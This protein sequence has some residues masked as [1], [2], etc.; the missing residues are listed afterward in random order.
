MDIRGLILVNEGADNDAGE[1]PW[2]T[3]AALLEVAGKSAV[4]RMT[5]RLERYG[6]S[7]VTTI[8]EAQP[9]AKASEENNVVSDRQRFWRAAEN[10]FN[11]MAQDGA[12][13]V[14]VVRLGSYAEADF[15]RLVQYHVE[16][17]CRVSKLGDAEQELEIFCISA[18]RRNDAASLFRSALT[19]C[20]TA[21]PTLAHQG[22]LN[23]L[24]G[25]ADLRQFAIDILMLKTE[26]APA[27]QEWRPGIW[28]APGAR[29]EKGARVIAP[30][31]VAKG[32]RVRSGA[33]ITRCSSIEH[34]AE[35]D[36]G[37]VVENSSVLPYSYIGAGLDLA[38]SVAGMGTVANLK[39]DA[40]VEIV[41]TR[42]VR[43]L[44]ATPGHSF[45]KAAGG[46][47]TSLA[48]QVWPR[49]TLPKHGPEPDL[50]AALRQTS[51]ALG[52]AAGFQ[53]PAC[54]TKAADEL[55]G[56]VVARRYGNE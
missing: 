26:T 52:T 12:E 51:P 2:P 54:D 28:V 45:F 41:D 6:V 49:P 10:A 34:H 56:L 3:H 48:K 38:H 25:P 5:E 30:A 42:L 19:Q 47:L 33:V 9:D 1:F 50:N 40:L 11:E 13:I 18:S 22:Y 55:A 23:P 27:G 36:C 15:E 37:T 39:R 4:R 21:C 8:L 24:A 53:T 32:A 35:I 17:G 46:L 7:P 16:G 44:A 14:I 31:F 43:H 20:R 29:I